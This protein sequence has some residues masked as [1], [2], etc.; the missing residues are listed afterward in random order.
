[1]CASKSGLKGKWKI[2]RD[3]LSL[4]NGN[5]GLYVLADFKRVMN[6]HELKCAALLLQTVL[7]SKKTTVY[8]RLLLKVNEPSNKGIEPSFLKAILLPE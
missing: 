6:G 8:P 5:Y 1:M 2:I 4:F 7:H 3:L